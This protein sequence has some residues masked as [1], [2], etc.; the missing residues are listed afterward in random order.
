L[1]KVKFSSLDFADSFGKTEALVVV[2]KKKKSLRE[3]K[4]IYYRQ[5]NKEGWGAKSSDFLLVN[6]KQSMCVYVIYSKQLSQID[7]LKGIKKGCYPASFKSNTREKPHRDH[8]YEIFNHPIN[9]G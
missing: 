5:I 7:Y 2:D 1:D 3:L 9:G 8:Y 6:F 4:I